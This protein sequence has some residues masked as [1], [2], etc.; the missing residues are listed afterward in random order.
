MCYTWDAGGAVDEDEDHA[1]EGPRDA[2]EAHAGAPGV[3]ASTD[4]GGDGDVE[5]QQRGHELRDDGAVEA[6]PAQLLEVDERRRRRVRVVLAGAV[7]PQPRL[8]PSL[9]LHHRY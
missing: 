3:V 5:E 1:A 8:H 7:V 4:D 9:V 2:Q 6:P